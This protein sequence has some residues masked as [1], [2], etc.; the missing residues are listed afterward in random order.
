MRGSVLRKKTKN[1]FKKPKICGYKIIDKYR[2]IFPCKTFTAFAKKR[3]LFQNFQNRVLEL[4]LETNK[5]KIKSDCKI[6]V[7]KNFST[8]SSFY[9]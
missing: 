5:Y 4:E 6:V 9:E 1:L 7:F 3:T 8:I 2:K